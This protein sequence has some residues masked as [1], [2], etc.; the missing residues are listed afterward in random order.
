MDAGVPGTE[1]VHEA[2]IANRFSTDL[3]CAFDRFRLSLLDL[4]ENRDPRLD[5]ARARA[6]RHLSAGDAGVDLD[7]LPVS[8]LHGFVSRVEDAVDDVPVDEILARLF[9]LDKALHEM[10]HLLVIAVDA[11]L[12]GNGKHPAD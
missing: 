5:P 2:A 1:E 10:P 9:A 12:V 7:R 8:T 4:I 11:R 6:H 3:A